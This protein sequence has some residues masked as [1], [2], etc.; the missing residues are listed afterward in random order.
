MCV[1]VWVSEWSRKV[2][3]PSVGVRQRKWL[4]KKLS[5][6][7]AGASHSGIHLIASFGCRLFSHT[8]WSSLNPLRA[9]PIGL[10][11]LVLLMRKIVRNTLTF[12]FF[13]K[14]RAGKTGMISFVGCYFFITLDFEYDDK[15][16]T[17]PIA[18]L[19][20]VWKVLLLMEGFL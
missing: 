2:S 18:C 17:L 7:P 11:S 9:L 12:S 4:I 14:A 15:W 5:V 19:H 1:C 13:A 16:L 3:I 20:F 6:R 8:G 10:L